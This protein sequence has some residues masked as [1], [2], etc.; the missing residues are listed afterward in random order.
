M[1][2][3]EVHSVILGAGPAGLAA[4]YT[5]AKAGC[6]PVVFEKGKVS[7]GLMRSIKRGDFVVDIGRKELYNRLPKV[8]AFWEELLGSEYC[9][10]PHRGG[11]LF[12]GHIIEISSSFRGFRRGMPWPMLMGCTWD[13]LSS[14][15]LPSGS[16]PRN[17]EEYFYQKRGRRLSQVISQGF[18]EK[19]AGVKW[20][21]VSLPENY[22][23]SEDSSMFNTIKALMTRALAKK[24]VNTSQG[25]WRHPAKGTGQICEALER[26][27]VQ[28]GGRVFFEANVL[29]MSSSGGV[30][31]A[32]K[33]EVGT[34]TVVFKPMYVISSIP[35]HFLLKL[36]L[37]EGFETLDGSL[38]A[39]PSSKKTIVLVYLFLDE[40]P[41]FPHGW[42]NVTCRKTRIGRITNYTGINS[43]MVPKG[44]TCLCCEFYCYAGD[45]LLELDNKA[46]AQLALEECAKYGL[47]D[48]TKCFDE[49]VIRLP[50]ADASQ[51]RHNWMSNMRQG[52]LEE[53]RRFKNLYYVS[54]TDLDIATLAGIE[55]AE[56]V[57]S[58]DR[59]TFDRHIDA[60]E[61]DIQSTKKTFE[62]RNP[63]EQGI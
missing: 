11:V 54:R 32:I 53:L 38:K 27:I 26:G 31:D 17:L 12:D 4:G 59:S 33:A 24:E 18:Q 9:P 19:L 52:L 51:N 10:Y 7:G 37:K 56:A 44:K 15:V 5:L 57:L 13:L 50:G 62:F 16:K 61:L 48:P 47:V 49:L 63:T 35:S 46:F 8:D 25:L 20:A 30:I 23:D 58:G 55:A 6:A 2:T 40:D 42:L 43:A 34:E 36:L 29:E 39:P 41:R 3:E 22:E 21:D 60:N 14:Q 45:S 1:R 28:R